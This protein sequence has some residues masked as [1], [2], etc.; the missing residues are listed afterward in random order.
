MCI[1]TLLTSYINGTHMEASQ[2]ACMHGY[3]HMQLYGY[4]ILN[5]L[6]NYVATQL[7][8][9]Y[10]KEKENHKQQITD[11]TFCHNKDIL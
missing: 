9:W 4:A 3:G 8:Y 6:C 10:L 11:N 7:R 1:T 2:S 5:L